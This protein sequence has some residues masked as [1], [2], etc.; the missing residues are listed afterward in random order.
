MRLIKSPYPVAATLFVVA[1][2][3]AV[4]AKEP[5]HAEI[6]RLRDAGVVLSLEEVLNRAGAGNVLLGKIVEAVLEEH[7]GRYIYEIKVLD[8]NGVL[9]EI[10]LDAS[11]GASLG[12]ETKR[13]E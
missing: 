12:T 4:M 8:K 6:K 2:S 7:D 5:D 11:T 1:I 13:H 10:V 3:A 9:K